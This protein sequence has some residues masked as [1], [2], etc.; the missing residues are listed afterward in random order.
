MSLRNSYYFITISQITKFYKVAYI[1]YPTL[2]QLMPTHTDK[3]PEII[4]LD[5]IAWLPLMV[6]F[7]DSPLIPFSPD[8]LSFLIGIIS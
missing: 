6:I 1:T 7:F 4:F 3:T 5:F 2:S 8:S